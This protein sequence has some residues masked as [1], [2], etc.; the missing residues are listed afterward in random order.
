MTPERWQM[1]CG[2][3][4][5]ALELPVAE[6]AAF[7]ESKCSGDP[8]LR[9][10]VDHYL[11]IEHKLDPGFLRYPATQQ[12]VGSAPIATGSTMLAPGT[13][14][15][16]YEVQALLGAGGM[17]EVYRGRDTRLNRTVAIKVIP[18]GVSSDQLRQQRFER[19]ARAISALQ[20]PNICTLYDVGHQDGTQ[21]LVMEYLEGETLAKRLLKGPLPLELILRYTSEVADALDA[22]HRRGIV[23]RDLKPANIFLTAHG[24]AKVLDFGLAKLD[25]PETKVETSAETATNEKLLTIPGIAMGTAPYMSPEQARGDDL[26]A[27]TDIFSLGTVLYEMATGKMAF[28]GKTTAKV[29]KA[30]L[31][32]TPPPPSKVLHSIPEALDHIVTKALEKDRDLRW[33]DAADLRADLNR[34]KRDITS[35]RVAT[36]DLK[37]RSAPQSKRKRLLKWLVSATAMLTGGAIAG[38]YMHRPLPR[39]RICKSSPNVRARRRMLWPLE[40]GARVPRRPYALDDRDHRQ[41][42]VRQAIGLHLA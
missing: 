42:L 18:R 24:E 15:G 2:I 36:A 22:A 40:S 3:L 30:I 27:R 5:S 14:L 7:L 35:G 8:L 4:E 21:F 25:E 17:G 28:S 9:E 32:K 29:H 20:H 39:P 41:L 11:S 12:V 13:R 26:D 31:D 34:L 16:P 10:D 33:Q 6:R 38:W 1:V 19:E 23:H 37:V